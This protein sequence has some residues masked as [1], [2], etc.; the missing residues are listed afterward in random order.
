MRLRIGTKIAGSFAI[1]LILALVV[2]A[3]GIISL[4]SYQKSV[5]AASAAKT[6]DTMI[7]E[8]RTIEK[9]FILRGDDSYLSR[10]EE[11]LEKIVTLTR[12]TI[13]IVDK[14][15]EKQLL[16]K[17]LDG[18]SSYG[19]AFN[20]M[21]ESL[22]KEGEA[23]ATWV[24]VGF[25]FTDSTQEVKTESIYPAVAAAKASEDF[26]SLAKWQEIETYLEGSIVAKF[27][28]VRYFAAVFAFTDKSDARWEAFQKVIGEFEENLLTWK[29][30]GGGEAAVTT[31]ISR[32]QAALTDYRQASEDFRRESLLQRQLQEEMIIAARNGQEA[33]SSVLKNF[34]ADQA[35]AR[36]NASLVIISV[37]ALA[38]V[39]GVLL[40]I[41]ISRGISIAMKKGVDFA[42]SISEGHLDARL[43]YSSKD[44]IGDLA[45]ALREMVANL[46]GIVLDV[47]SAAE[48]VSTGSNEISSAAQHLSE[49][50]TQQAS[51]AEE[52]SSSMEEMSSS[53]KQ[54]SDNSS[55]T[56]KIAVRVAEDAEKGG[57]AVEKTVEAMHHIS[58]KIQVIN[59]ISRQ[60]NLL[61]LNAAI[62][63]ARAGE[64]GKGFAVVASE[65]RK[66]AER[67]QVAATEIIDLTKNSV[68]VAEEAGELLRSIVPEI[69]KTADLVQ[70]ISASSGEQ[71]SGAN[72]INQ[73]IIQ[74]DQ[75][76]Q[77]NAGFSEEMAS[78]SEELAGQAESLTQTMAW[79]TLKEGGGRKL[80]EEDKRSSQKQGNQRK[81]NQP[82]S[83]Q[84]SGRQGREPTGI[85]PADPSPL[86]EKPRQDSK[87]DS[88]RSNTTGIPSSAILG[89]DQIHSGGPD[90]LDD[91]FEEF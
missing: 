34:E 79:F 69:K 22:N 9:N 53:I 73:A 71:D 70:E 37:L 12:D 91:D 21:V 46:K 90:K 7:L 49:G 2:G 30:I 67:S 15:E 64:Q 55:Q 89:D 86:D 38:L 81:G 88:K 84:S 75:I 41:I 54:N 72:Q 68:S 65:V 50:A 78:M 24:D 26:E 27:W 29:E 23:I 33:I 13:D 14:Q 82:Q 3:A 61:A 39:V 59:E 8:A 74:L 57:Q 63:A 5:E 87:Q 51:A 60:T 43:D 19:K 48:S 66:L 35:T 47:N 16:Q 20:N 4:Q 32:I 45:D 6:L 44:E 85:V 25:I 77:Q 28:S 17:V 52:V 11:H 58:E 62:E 76:I 40:A 31:A 42:K 1:I 83:W 36:L 10:M 56:E 18:G 80:L